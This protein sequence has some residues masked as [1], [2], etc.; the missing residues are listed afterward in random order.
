MKKHIF[1]IDKYNRLK[2]AGVKGKRLAI[3]LGYSCEA[4]LSR[5]K[6]EYL[7]KSAK[8]QIL[9][10]IS[11]IEKI[12]NNKKPKENIEVINNPEVLETKKD[13]NPKGLTENKPKN[14]VEKE[15]VVD[16]I[17]LIEE[18][19]VDLIKSTPPRDLESQDKIMAI[20]SLSKTMSSFI[21]SM[22]KINK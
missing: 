16:L 2:L 6:R 7:K 20:S 8:N 11:F 1:D 5:A 4:S 9:D 15:R 10:T 18:Y 17:D 14:I 3:K 19:L 12:K 22:V 21:A 13:D